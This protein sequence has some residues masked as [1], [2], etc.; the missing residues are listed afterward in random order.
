MKIL[1]SVLVAALAAVLVLAPARLALADP[2][3]VKGHSFD[4]TFT[5][6]VTSP[7]APPVLLN[8]VGV[9]GGDAG[10]GTYTGEVLSM[11]TVGNITTIVPL[12]HFHGSRHSFTAL[13]TVKQDDTLGTAQITGVVTDGW[14]KGAP[15][16]G[17]Y[18]V[19]PVCPI[20]T[21]G[22]MLGTVCFQG[23]LHIHR[24]SQK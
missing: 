21:P 9:V 17:E 14:Q 23:A 7:G 12:Y 20:P 8:M 2:G 19:L 5:K 10:D 16:T 11:N 6:W 18:T 13:L 3:G 1:K 15:V 4:S 24:G 22:N